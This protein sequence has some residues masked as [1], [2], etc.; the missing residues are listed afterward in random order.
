MRSLLRGPVKQE[1]KLESQSDQK[2][3][4]NYLSPVESDIPHLSTCEV[5]LRPET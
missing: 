4:G 5:I 3:N 2:Q 1:Y